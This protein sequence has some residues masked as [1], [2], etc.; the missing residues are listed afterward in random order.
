M[1]K[2]PADIHEIAD[3][4]LI[5]RL[6]PTAFVLFWEKLMVIKHLERLEKMGLVKPIGNGLYTAA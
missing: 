4:H 1:K 5:Y 6:H 2:K 3:Q